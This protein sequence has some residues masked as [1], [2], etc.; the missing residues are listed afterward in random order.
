MVKSA[1][2]Y[3]LAYKKVTYALAAV[4]TFLAAF[5]TTP[6]GIALVK[7][8]PKLTVVFVASTSLGLLVHTPTPQGSGNSKP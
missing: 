3:L 2:N 1:M 5:A 7:Q 8:Y 6:A 4:V